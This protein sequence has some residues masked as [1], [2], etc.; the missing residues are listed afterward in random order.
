MQALSAAG[1]Y[2]FL[3]CIGYLHPTRFATPGVWP[4]EK[5]VAACLDLHF[6]IDRDR[7]TW[8]GTLV[9]SFTG[10]SVSGET[11]DQ[12]WNTRGL[13]RAD[14]MDVMVV[15]LKLAFVRAVNGVAKS[16]GESRAWLG[17]LLKV[18]RNI[19]A[20][21]LMQKHTV[22]HPRPLC[23]QEFVF[24][25]GGEGVF[26][27]FK[28]R[29][30][31]FLVRHEAGGEVAR[32]IH[33]FE[34]DEKVELDMTWAGHSAMTRA[35]QFCAVQ[36]ALRDEGKSSGA[37]HVAKAFLD[38]KIKVFNSES[39]PSP[40]L[41][42]CHI[43]VL[44]RFQAMPSAADMKPALFWV[45]QVEGTFGRR[46]PLESIYLLDQLQKSCKSDEDLSHVVSQALCDYDLHQL[47]HVVIKICIRGRGWSCVTLLA[48]SPYTYYLLLLQ[49]QSIFVLMLRNAPTATRDLTVKAVSAR[50]S[51]ELLKQKIIKH[52]LERFPVFADS[53]ANFL[54]PY[55]WHEAYP[56]L[57]S[58]PQA[59]H[60]HDVV[61]TTT[62]LPRVPVFKSNC[63]TELFKILVEILLLT[64]QTYQSMMS[65]VRTSGAVAHCA[66]V[67]DKLALLQ[68]M[69]QQEC[70][71]SLS[72]KEAAFSGAPTLSDLTVSTAEEL[73][74]MEQDWTM[75][76]DAFY[77][78]AAQRELE[79]RGLAQPIFW[80]L[81]GMLEHAFAKSAFM[82]S[83]L[84]NQGGIMFFLDLKQ[85]S[86]RTPKSRV[87]RMSMHI[88]VS[89]ER[90][91]KFLDVIW[92]P[93]A[94]E[95]DVGVLMCGKSDTCYRKCLQML[96]AVKPSL[97][98]RN[99][100]LLYSEEALRSGGL[101]RA[102]YMLSLAPRE[103]MILFSKTPLQLPC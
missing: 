27:W 61:I 91:Q 39:Q 56:P 24:V 2:L 21:N 1:E 7:I 83:K 9:V 84:V 17:K 77:D 98:L 45:E 95:T 25:V 19:P 31:K 70:M 28:S 76:R 100:S 4:A 103:Y 5:A 16:C 72:P 58:E 73:S 79:S 86:A 62:M 42:T 50:A 46:G 68:A 67:M 36:Q 75:Q 35:K 64:G 81:D 6:G 13:W 78:M 49:V 11:M 88:A 59:D 60:D 38:K 52:C 34:L 26:F 37:Q 66:A 48:R 82:T 51:I 54:T 44:T 47:L 89:K 80:T 43:R 10:P 94:T 23:F 30:T 12:W 15:A 85:L 92:S 22:A 97:F 90:L 32:M 33:V 41:V 55:K 96:H 40:Y 99:Q 8:P 20:G 57:S 101:A 69:Y 74:S 71:G 65:V 87:T 63:Q 53:F 29:V 18:S 14:N 93:H 3:G 102:R